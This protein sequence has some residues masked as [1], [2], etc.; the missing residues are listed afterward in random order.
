[1]WNCLKVSGFDN[2]YSIL[3][4]DVSKKYPNSIDEIESYI[5]RGKA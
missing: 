5:D 4:M 1:M 3:E 2:L